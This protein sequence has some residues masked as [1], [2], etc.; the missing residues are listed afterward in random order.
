MIRTFLIADLR[1]YTT[2]SDAR[3]DQAAAD[4]SERFIAIATDCV[5][6]RS[7]TV[8]EVR[9]DEVLAAF[10]SAREALRAAVD[11]QER[12]ATEPAEREMLGVG[13]GLDAGEAVPLGDGYRGRA[14]N[15]AARLCARARA[16]EILVTSELI[17]L[18]G[19]VEGIRFEDR[20]AVRLK[21]LSRP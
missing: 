9:G 6:G 5:K 13:I 7:G 3:G 19:A 17:H 1:G 20:G 14:L 18:A 21:G 12:A 11:L 4:V 15:L 8:V 16:G 10:E 2:F